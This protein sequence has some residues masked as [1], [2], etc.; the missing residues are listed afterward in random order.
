[1]C[2]LIRPAASSAYPRGI[3]PSKV[4]TIATPAHPSDDPPRIANNQCEIWNIFDHYCSGSDKRI[5][6]DRD[7]TYDS[8][9]CPKSCTSSYYSREKFVLALD[10]AP[11]IPH[12]GKNH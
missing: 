4:D 6:P 7:P 8:T 11:R 12:I 10:L 3:I 2:F 1:M 5:L 9:I